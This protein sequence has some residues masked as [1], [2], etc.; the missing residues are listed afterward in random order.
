MF[1]LVEVEE[2]VRIAP[3]ELNRKPVEAIT[4]VLK[5]NFL[6]KVIQDIGLVISLY[7]ILSLDGGL[8]HQG[9][10][11][12]HFQVRFRLVVFR[13][14]VGEVLIGRI[15]KCDA[16]GVYVTLGFFWDIHIPEHL[17]QIPSYFDEQEKVWIWKFNENEMFMDLQE[18]VRFRVAAVKYPPLPLEQE[19]GAKPFAP[20]QLVGD[21]NAD[22]LGLVSWWS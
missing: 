19:K 15:Q 5:S 11:A 8:V 4:S 13:P 22:G 17:L 7:D 14:F 16:S 21:I 12:P 6:D 9:D 20:M 18:E 10:G 1:A 2:D 3:Q